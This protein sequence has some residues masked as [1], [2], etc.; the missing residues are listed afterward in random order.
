MLPG[1]AL[2]EVPEMP[3][4][5]EAELPGAGT[6]RERDAPDEGHAPGVAERTE[7]GNKGEEEGGEDHPTKATTMGRRIE[8]V[9]V[10]SN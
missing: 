3:L 8:R 1:A 2:G 10:G 4:T 6:D 7:H 9:T 5:E